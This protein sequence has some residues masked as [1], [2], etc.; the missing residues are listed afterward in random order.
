MKYK[1][2][3]NTGTTKFAHAL[4]VSKRSI[5]G[6][7]VWEEQILDVCEAFDLELLWLLF[8]DLSDDH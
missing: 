3:V 6:L 2:C 5:E 7:G 4:S 8:N 1:T